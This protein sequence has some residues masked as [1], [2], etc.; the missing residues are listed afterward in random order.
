MTQHA[1]FVSRVRS[2]ATG[3][4]CIA[5]I[6]SGVHAQVLFLSFCFPFFLFLLYFF[7]LSFLVSPFRVFLLSSFCFIF[8]GS[9]FLPPIYV[10]VTC[11][12]IYVYCFS[13]PYFFP[14][15]VFVF[16]SSLLYL[17]NFFILRF[18]FY[19][20]FVHSFL[21]SLFL[22]FCLPFQFLWFFFLSF[23]FS[24][25]V[26]P[27]S[28]VLLTPFGN[29]TMTNYT[30]WYR[31]IKLY[32][33]TIRTFPCFLFFSLSGKD[34]SHLHYATNVSTQSVDFILSFIVRN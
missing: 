6:G 2:R 12:F 27:S 11:F 33:N 1:K 17:Y 20:S 16:F 3:E 7:L 24:S 21:I 4:G 31:S 10:F 32:V 14:L 5:C 22:S 23:S 26:F 9:F 28:A 18:S 30:V 15:S 29:I 19:P 13:L 25:T 34:S 8:S